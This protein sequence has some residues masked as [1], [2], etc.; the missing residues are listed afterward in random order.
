MA[1]LTSIVRA[2]GFATLAQGSLADTSIQPRD[3]GYA[4]ASALQPDGDGSALTGLPVDYVDA[5]ALSLFNV[6]GSAPVYACR[7]WVNFNGSGTV[8]IRAS[9]NVSSITDNGTGDFT[10]NFATAM[11][12]ASY[13]YT[14]SSVDN[15]TSN[16]WNNQAASSAVAGYVTASSLRLVTSVSGSEGDS[17]I[18][19]VAIFR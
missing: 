11:E 6:S 4:P 3:S 16:I 18:V 12:D 1:T 5:D 13:A 19:T 15:D 8:S 2:A 14:A 17:Q 10:V 7:A 9:G